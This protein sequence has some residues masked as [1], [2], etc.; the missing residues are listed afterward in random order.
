MSDESPERHPFEGGGEPVDLAQF[1]MELTQSNMQAA[2]ALAAMTER[3]HRLAKRMQWIAIIFAVAM[4]M[5][6]IGNI[7]DMIAEGIR[8]G[9]FG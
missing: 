5:Y 8:F 2:A 1:L 7:F 3:M 9:K 6:V 4:G